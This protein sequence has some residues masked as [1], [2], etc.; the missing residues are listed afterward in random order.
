[1]SYNTNCYLYVAIKSRLIYEPGRKSEEEFIP[2]FVVQSAKYFVWSATD[3]KVKIF[4]HFLDHDINV[5]D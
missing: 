5:V 3:S 4:F 2:F 1:M